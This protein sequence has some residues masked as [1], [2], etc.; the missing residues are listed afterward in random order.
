MAM[1]TNPR[2]GRLSQAALDSIV[3]YAAHNG[4]QWRS[5]L[6]TDWAC[7]NKQGKTTELRQVRNVIGP[8][9]LHH[10]SKDGRPR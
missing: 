9:G 8:S 1:F 6:R 5:R 2:Y 7:D 4:V 3:E 10:F